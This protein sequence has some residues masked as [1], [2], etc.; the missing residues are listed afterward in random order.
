MEKNCFRVCLSSGN[1]KIDFNLNQKVYSDTVN[2]IGANWNH[3]TVTWSSSKG[4]AVYK[5][6]D[7]LSTVLAPTTASDNFR[8]GIQHL[9]MGFTNSGNDVIHIQ[10]LKI[11]RFVL[12]ADEVAD[13]FSPGNYALC[14]LF[15]FLSIIQVHSLASNCATKDKFSREFFNFE[16]YYHYKP[17]RIR[18]F[19]QIHLNF[20]TLFYLCFLDEFDLPPF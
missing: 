16:H 6:G 12:S 3:Y 5:N 2:S 13:L 11:W 1:L 10:A 20:R 15:S 7:W 14:Y 18:S 19:F 17:S 8:N 4:L 9:R